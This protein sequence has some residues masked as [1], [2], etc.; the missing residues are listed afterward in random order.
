MRY[1][2]AR[3][4]E[5]ELRAAVL[6]ASFATSVGDTELRAARMIHS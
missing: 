6:L 4:V 1:A 3:A 5:S 2:V